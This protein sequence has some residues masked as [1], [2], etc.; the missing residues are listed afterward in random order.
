[1]AAEPPGGSEVHR[2]IS[3]FSSQLDQ[4]SR[5]SEECSGSYPATSAC[6]C[7]LSGPPLIHRSLELA[8]GGG[9]RWGL[10]GLQGSCPLGKDS[11]KVFVV[12]AD[13]GGGEGLGGWGV[14]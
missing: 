6:V 8:Q 10:G 2:G 9:G 5:V 7:E 1:M 4:G 11:T 13:R 14:Q 3:E 12:I